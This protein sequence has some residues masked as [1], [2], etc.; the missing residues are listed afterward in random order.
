MRA[1]QPSPS[2]ADAVQDAI[3]VAILSIAAGRDRGAGKG[4]R[5]SIIAIGPTSVTVAIFIVVTTVGTIAVL[6]DGIAQDFHCAKVPCRVTVVAIVRR[7]V[8]IAVPI[9]RVD[10]VAVVVYAVASNFGDVRAARRVVVIAVQILRH[11]VPILI[12]E[13]EVR[14]V[15][16]FVHLVTPDFDR[17]GMHARI[18]VVAVGGRWM[19]VSVFITRTRVG[20][21]AA[22]KT[23][24]AFL[25][26]GRGAP[27]MRRKDLAFLKDDAV[28]HNAGFGRKWDGCPIGGFP[29][30]A[31][32]QRV[33]GLVEGA[34]H[35]EWQWQRLWRL[36]QNL[37]GPACCASGARRRMNV[38]ASARRRRRRRGRP[39]AG[40]RF[41][42]HQR[43]AKGG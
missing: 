34:P 24:P 32:G 42:H 40:C 2:R 22:A 10:P 9:A 4:Q 5:I 7:V 27:G 30:L 18:I 14:S 20:A 13:A 17:A 33:H 39:R 37:A 15:A 12:G 11:T 6:V 28:V 16:V 26:L 3:A 43:D 23:G 21:L 1:N 29:D 38:R 19:T 35:H 36:S 8:P 41:P 25:D 31:R